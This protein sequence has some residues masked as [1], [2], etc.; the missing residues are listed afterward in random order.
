M[1]LYQIGLTLLP[2]IGSKLGK[3][4]VSYC[5][6]VEAVFSEKK[7]AL[8]KIPGINAKVAAQIV[9]HN[10]LSRAEREVKY[11]ERNNIKTFFYLDKEYP[12]RLKHCSDNP[13]MLYFKGEANF[14]V[15]R[16]VSIVGTRKA[17][18]YGKMV[19]EKLVSDLAAYNVQIIS[20]LAYGIDACAHHQ[21]VEKGLS[22]IGVLGHGLDRLYPAGNFSLSKK[23]QGNG[24][25]LT[26]F[27]S[28][29]IPDRENFPK[30]NRIVAGMSDAVIVVESGKKG[31]ALITADIANSYFRD[32]FAF[33]AR[34][35]DTYSLG[36]N[37]LIK[38]NRAA[39]IEDYRDVLY[40][41]GWD[42]TATK[43]PRQQK[44]FVELNKEEQLVVDLLA[45]EGV[46]TIDQ[47]MIATKI[48]SSKMASILLNLEFE[49]VLK[50]LPGKAYSL[51]D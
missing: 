49:G 4:L 40:I 27:L 51:S 14:N 9:N 1:L 42:E 24:G 8:E 29:T 22:T 47:L 45:Q 36:C 16:T 46:Q 21:A 13:I 28:G 33:P 12:E 23:M 41:M 19:C 3:E 31:G 35:N 18:S 39:L 48:R 2:N 37:N 20:G 17:T 10:V 6:G 50:C 26:E 30:R 15:K 32:V 5:G 11:I 38:T 7:S 43:V 34:V 25:L 44:L